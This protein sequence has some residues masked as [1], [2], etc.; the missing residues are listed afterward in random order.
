MSE[1]FDYIIIG[2]G[3]AG[4]LLANRI[5]MQSDNTVCVLEA[6][7]KDNNP[8][9]HIPAGFVKTIRDQKI[10][11][12]Y[13]CE[14]GAWTSGRR[15]SQPRGKVLGGSGSINGH[16]FNRG[17]RSDFDEWARRGNNGWGYADVLPYFKRF[18]NFHGACDPDFRGQH[19]EF[20]VT[21][22]EWRHPLLSAFIK[23]ANALG[24]HNNSDYN[25]QDQN[26]VAY[27]QRS[28]C[29]GVRAS[30]AK[31]FLRP[32]MRRKN[33]RVET[34]A[35][36]ETIDFRDRKATGVSYLK[37]R[38][39]FSINARR[40][41]ILCGG[42][43]NSPQLLQ[44]SGIGSAHFL[45]QFGISV[46]HDLPGVGEN[47]RD[48]CYSPVSARVK[49]VRSLN[50]RSRGLSLLG[51]IAYYLLTRK[52]LLSMQPSMVYISTR[53]DPS[54]ADND[55]QISFG[56][57]SYDA[58]RDMQLNK[59]PGVTCAPWQH[60]PRSKG[61]VRIASRS[62]HDAPLIQP[63]Y[64]DDEYDRKILLAACRLARKLLRTNPF[65]QFFD[66]EDNPGD[67]VETDDEWLDYIK[68]TCG[69]TYHPMGSCRMGPKS[70]TD[71]V[72]D[73][74]LRVHGIENLR[75]VDASIMPTM[76][77]GNTNAATLMI[78]EK[79]ADMILGRSPLPAASLD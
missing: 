74:Q 58:S 56:P 75:V 73:S 63:N 11:W 68:Q 41:V 6:G 77:S 7:P 1:S 31:A 8:F 49:N 61:Y 2:A 12:L 28:I 5:A 67:Q 37:D 10:N 57:A 54:L 40:E 18:E 52:G 13:T 15:V 4:C 42:V 70:E 64:L 59:Y 50:E 35:L 23:S 62:I 76:T 65:A 32:A 38:E 26:G 34:N 30:P 9:I 48:H 24:I 51:E 17:Q 45:N 71:S 33:L 79:G 36:V 60:V 14:P 46:V 22:P 16:I 55:I 27:A 29:R 66:Y 43:F 20:D 21:N 19:G 53:S 25:G 47:L 72:V 78:A 69:T 39:R 3:S 44:L